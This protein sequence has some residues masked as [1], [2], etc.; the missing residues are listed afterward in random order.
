MAGERRAGGRDVVR[1]LVLA[2]THVPQRARD[3]PVPV[4][5]AAEEADLILHAGDVVDGWV[6]AAL[7]RFAPVAAVR[8]NLDGDE[9]GTPPRRVLEVAGVRVGLVHGHEGRGRT[10][11]ER[12][13]EAFPGR[14]VDVIVFGHSHQPLLQRDPDGVLLLNPGSP[15]DPRHAPA[16]SFAWLRVE[17]GRVEAEH[18]FLEGR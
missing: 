11:P 18:V 14:T 2:D 16:P 8:G 12:A 1:V 6:L 9:L 13:R 5:T 10:A 7:A 4:W 17:G 3:L 15:T